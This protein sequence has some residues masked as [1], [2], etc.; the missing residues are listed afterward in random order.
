VRIQSRRTRTS[1]N[2]T[3]LETLQ[4]YCAAQNP[5]NPN[6]PQDFQMFS[7]SG[8]R[9]GAGTGELNQVSSFKQALSFRTGKAI[10]LVI[11]NGQ[12]PRGICFLTLTR[13]SH[14]QQYGL[15][16]HFAMNQCDEPSAQFRR[17][18]KRKTKIEKRSY[19]WRFL[20]LKVPFRNPKSLNR[21]PVAGTD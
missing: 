20:A 11:P 10:K 6:I 2:P 14:T 15:P 17:R 3:V 13:S 21:C 19:V 18:S 12:S 5:V 7:T 9:P 8:I 16:L 4:T 1:A